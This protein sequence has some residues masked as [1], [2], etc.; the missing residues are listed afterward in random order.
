MEAF[1]WQVANPYVL[2]VTVQAGDIDEFG[3][4]NNVVY[5]GW[6]ERAAWAH[7]QALGLS[8][9]DYRRLGRGLVARKHELEYLAPSF[10]DETLLVGTWIS[11][12]DRKLSIYRGYQI[13]RPDDGK[14][15]LTGSTHWVSIDL[16]SGRPR[17]MPT[18]FAELYPAQV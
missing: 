1:S 9:E 18:E 5:L 15:I 4:T 10:E 7:S 13:I 17:R 6:L 8:M 3:H 14:T 11:G 12:N 16:E 2:E